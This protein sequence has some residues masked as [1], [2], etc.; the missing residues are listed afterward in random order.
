MQT[1]GKTTE[2]AVV[3]ESQ[4]ASQPD[5]KRP[6]EIAP[7]THPALALERV[8]A[9]PAAALSASD[10]LALQRTVGNRAVQRFLSAPPA[11]PPPAIQV[12][13]VVGAANDHYEQEADRVADRV[14]RSSAVD[15]A[16]AIQR[17]EQD[18]EPLQMKLLPKAF[19]PAIEREAMPEHADLRLKPMI[20]PAP[21]P[22][23]SSIGSGNH[24]YRIQRGKG[25]KSAPSNNDEK[26]VT[27][28]KADFT[29]PIGKV[30]EEEERFRLIKEEIS[31]EIKN[32]NLVS[33]SLKAYEAA[34]EIWKLA[35]QGKENNSKN[36]ST[37]KNKP[38]ESSSYA[39]VI[40]SGPLKD[41]RS[42]IE[43][44]KEIEVAVK[45]LTDKIYGISPQLSPHEGTLS[46]L[47]NES[48]RRSWLDNQAQAQMTEKHTAATN[49]L[50]P[51]Q[52]KLKA[53]K[54]AKTGLEAIRLNTVEDKRAETKT[55]LDAARNALTNSSME[56][57]GRG[58]HLQAAGRLVTDLDTPIRNQLVVMLETAMKDTKDEDNKL[59]I[60]NEEKVAIA[61]KMI[62]KRK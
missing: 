3:A 49:E 7:G 61:N 35:K 58:Q 31:R 10:I 19:T 21:L 51:F 56:G 62:E 18:P 57:L 17:Q 46:E 25:K 27:P 33:E 48:W 55:E 28:K 34:L 12:K 11:E 45:G 5:D 9:L 47:S 36:K 30:E 53:L 13:L 16:P 22:Q 40:L 2:K 38:K 24:V 60:K 8:K 44:A 54:D 59:D 41:L 29:A 26:S 50:A 52:A 6:M 20:R 37:S 23:I 42:D 1:T 14:A 43:K 32:Q 4:R 39:D 15:A